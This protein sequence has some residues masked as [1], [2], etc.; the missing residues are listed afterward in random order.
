MLPSC[1]TDE[2]IVEIPGFR[3][4]LSSLLDRRMTHSRQLGMIS[5]FFRIQEPQGAAA[6]EPVFHAGAEHD[7]FRRGIGIGAPAIFPES[8]GVHQN[9]RPRFAYRF[10]RTSG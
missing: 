8:G 7:D 4:G 1:M 3:S 6:A 2:S 5:I 9:T 10:V